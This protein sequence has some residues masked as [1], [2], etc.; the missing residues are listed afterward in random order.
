[1]V[2]LD[3]PMRPNEAKSEKESVHPVAYREDVSDINSDRKLKISSLSI[4]Q[5]HLLLPCTIT[6]DR[7][8]FISQAFL[9]CGATDDFYDIDSAHKRNLPLETLSQPRQLYLVDGTPASRITHTTTLK[10]ELLGHKE[11]LKLFLTNLGKYELILG[12]KWLRKHNPSIN[13]AEDSINF[14]STY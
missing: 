9:D 6:A 11:T 10:I 2:R 1:M 5:D 13:W 12:R 8:S 14:C 4:Y 7:N 3:L